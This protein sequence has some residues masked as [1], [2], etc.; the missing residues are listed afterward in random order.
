[1]GYT[2]KGGR[3]PNSFPISLRWKWE[4]IVL[5]H[6][7]DLT[8]SNSY[9]N[10]SSCSSQNYR[11]FCLIMAQNLLEMNSIHPKMRP[12]LHICQVT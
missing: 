2:D 9:I 6:L 10:F 4:K 7:L 8:T 11:K 3:M 1:M 5:C 12:N